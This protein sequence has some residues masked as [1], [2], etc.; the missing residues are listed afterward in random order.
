MSA[1]QKL[2]LLLI[3][4]IALGAA[5]G[6][7]LLWKKLIDPRKNF[8]SLLLYFAAHF[9]SIFLITFLVNLVILK[10]ANFLFR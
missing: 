5:Y 10:M 6:S 4:I 2:L 7:H 9:G 8:G 3:F 1:T